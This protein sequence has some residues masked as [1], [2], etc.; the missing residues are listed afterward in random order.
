MELG[1]AEEYSIFCS[2]SIGVGIP[3]ML[4]LDDVLDIWCCWYGW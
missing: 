1:I 2:F 4:E 3:V